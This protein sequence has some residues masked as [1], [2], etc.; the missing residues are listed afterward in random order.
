MTDW[1]CM[2][3]ADLCSSFPLPPANREDEAWMIGSGCHY[4]ALYLME[5]YH[6]T[7]EGLVIDFVFPLRDT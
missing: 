6:S 3:E 2:V 5:G 1:G 4:F 7:Q